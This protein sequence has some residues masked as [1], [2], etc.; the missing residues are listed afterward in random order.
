MSQDEMD[1]PQTFRGGVQE[2]GDAKGGAP[3]AAGVPRDQIDENVSDDADAQA[4]SSDALGGFASEEP[5][6]QVP[7]DGGDDADATRDG[8]ADS[9]SPART[10]SG[11][12]ANT[13]GRVG[14]EQADTPSDL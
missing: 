2:S 6:V 11:S 8:D 3:G 7:R 14:N 5:S 1:D 10:G 4:M 12:E 13:P 9:E